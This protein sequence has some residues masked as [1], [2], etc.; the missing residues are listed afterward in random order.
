MMRF[1]GTR[2]IPRVFD[3]TKNMAGQ[4]RWYEDR[5]INSE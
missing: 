5:S 4:C 1:D 2:K 3:R